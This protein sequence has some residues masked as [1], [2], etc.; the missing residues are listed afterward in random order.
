LIPVNVRRD[1]EHLALGNRVSG[2][3]ASLPIDVADARERLHLIAAEMRGHK[4]AG[5]GRAFDLAIG[6]AGAVPTALAPWVSRLAQLTTN[7]RRN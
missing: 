7:L 1:D 3:F 2:M 6:F 4:E 5:Q